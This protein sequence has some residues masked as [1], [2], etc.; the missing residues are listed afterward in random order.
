MGAC[1]LIRKQWDLAL[2]VGGSKSKDVSQAPGPGQLE[3]LTQHLVTGRDMSQIDRLVTSL[4]TL[5]SSILHPCFQFV[6]PYTLNPQQSSIPCI[7]F[8]QDLLDSVSGSMFA[9]LW[10]P[11]QGTALERCVSPS[12]S[13]GH[14]TWSLGWLFFG[15]DSIS[16]H[17][18]SQVGTG[19]YYAAEV[20]QVRN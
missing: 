16:M 10:K 19:P 12:S 8:L 17:I 14:C 7:R 5:C 18:P 2:E 15:L 6:L 11:Q 3:H 4:A 9:V 13:Q 1:Q 20:Q